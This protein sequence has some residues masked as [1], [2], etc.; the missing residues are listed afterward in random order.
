[1]LFEIV[2]R[3]AR[4]HPEER[5]CRKGSA[6]ADVRTRVSKDED[7]HAALMLRDASQRIWA[8]EA[9]APASRCDAPQHEG[10]RGA[11]HFGETKPSSFWRN[12]AKDHFAIRSSPRKR[13][14]MI[15][16]GGYGSRLSP[17]FREGRPGR[18][19]LGPSEGPTCG[20]AKSPP[21]QFPCFGVVIYN[22]FC[23]SNV[24]GRR[25][26]NLLPQ[27]CH[28]ICHPDVSPSVVIPCVTIRRHNVFGCEAPMP[29][30]RIHIGR[31]HP[32]PGPR[33]R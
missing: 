22:D 17:R 19:W 26:P 25:G 13:G 29:A 11:A 33:P 30:R 2:R 12:E 3:D 27:M 21:G 15:T 8:A 5:G 32:P 20:C 16:A 7:G 1:V 28:P 24:S 14:P 9:F 23:N 6:N 31:S 18:R 10:A 4:P